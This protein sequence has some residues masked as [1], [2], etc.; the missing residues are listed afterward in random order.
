MSAMQ[1]FGIKR[2]FLPTC[3]IFAT[4]RLAVRSLDDVR[5]PNLNLLLFKTPLGLT[6]ISA[7]K[8]VGI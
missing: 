5:A 6:A 7:R 4:P 3:D 2:Q 1:L 8:W